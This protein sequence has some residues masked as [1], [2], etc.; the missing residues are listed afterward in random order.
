MTT[1]PISIYRK[2]IEDFSSNVKT[3]RISHESTE[4]GNENTMGNK[5]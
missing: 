3:R 5:F 1:S 4:E 2:Y